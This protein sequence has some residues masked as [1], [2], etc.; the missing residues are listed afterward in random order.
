MDFKSL[1]LH[2]SFDQIFQHFSTHAGV[3]AQF[4]IPH[5]LLFRLSRISRQSWSNVEALHA[6]FMSSAPLQN[7]DFCH[8]V[9]DCAI[10]VKAQE[11]NRCPFD[12]QDYSF[13][14]V[15]HPDDKTLLGV[16]V[17]QNS[18]VDLLSIHRDMSQFSRHISFC[19][20]FARA[21]H[22][23]HVDDLTALY[24]YRYLPRVLDQEIERNHRQGKKFCLL[25][26]DIDYFK[27]INDGHGHLVGSQLLQEVAELLKNTIRSYDPLFRYGGD[28]FL[29]LLVDTDAGTGQKVAE[30]I[31]K[32]VETHDFLSGSES[33][34][35]TV[36][37]G[38]AVFPD[39]AKSSKEL[40]QLADQAMYYGKNK[41]RN[42]V[43]VA[44]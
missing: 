24:N 12:S 4:W 17:L 33:L 9:W 21:Q 26:M 41:S 5:E 34:K 3:G 25:F 39:H 42:I 18:G 29:A 1:D 22:L 6:L 38:L 14:P 16:L 2:K 27:R 20:A 11:T 15:E 13:V 43:F 7:E 32:T 23:A 35:L 44:S 40:I 30:R 19:G 31:R 37:I 28:E 10:R 36:S 8:W